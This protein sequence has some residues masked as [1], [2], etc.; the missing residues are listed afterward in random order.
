MIEQV[1]YG[2]PSSRPAGGPPTAR[3]DFLGATATPHRG[4]SDSRGS[5]A[6]PDGLQRE[7]VSRSQHDGVR[8]NV[9]GDKT[10]EPRTPAIGEPRPGPPRTCR[11]QLVPTW[12]KTSFGSPRSNVFKCC[13]HSVH[14]RLDRVVG[15]TLPDQQRRGDLLDRGPEGFEF[16]HPHELP[17]AADRAQTHLDRDALQ[18][19]DPLPILRGIAVFVFVPSVFESLV[20]VIHV[21][22]VVDSPGRICP[23]PSE[24]DERLVLIGRFVAYG[25]YGVSA[26]VVGR[27]VDHLED[28]LDKDTAAGDHRDRVSCFVV[29]VPRGC[30][31]AHGGDHGWITRH[32]C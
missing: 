29:S 27:P 10:T 20:E 17:L 15:D 4:H 5:V 25:P 16:I 19:F 7:C 32:A 11:Y 31:G 3:E 9:V 13:H 28:Y 22:I 18:G 30:C 21:G 1:P 24:G 8:V 23:R 12:S 14:G 26:V 6:A 2:L